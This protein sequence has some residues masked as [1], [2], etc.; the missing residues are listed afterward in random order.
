MDNEDHRANRSIE[1]DESVIGNES[2]VD[3]TS[4]MDPLQTESIED[5]KSSAN[6][7]YEDVD[8]SRTTEFKPGLV[9]TAVIGMTLLI[10]IVV[11][12]VLSP[13]GELTFPEFTYLWGLLAIVT[14]AT[15]FVYVYWVEKRETER[16]TSEVRE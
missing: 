15:G 14:I 4:T 6:L 9:S 3:E 10:A 12:T 16:A 2:D 7:R 13:F 1:T 11:P 8:L 5:V